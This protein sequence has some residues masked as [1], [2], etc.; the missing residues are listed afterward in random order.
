MSRPEAAVDIL[1]I[2]QAQ[3]GQNPATCLKNGQWPEVERN[4]RSMDSQKRKGDFSFEI[5][6]LL[7]DFFEDPVRHPDYS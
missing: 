3:I 1:S 5:S 6:P 4:N 2:R 7:S